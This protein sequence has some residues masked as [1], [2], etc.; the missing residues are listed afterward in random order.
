[1][2]KKA[3]Y[4]SAILVLVIAIFFF[5]IQILSNIAF[6]GNS[7]AK[8]QNMV[9]L[10][11]DDGPNP[12]YTPQILDILRQHNIKATFFVLGSKAEKHPGIIKRIAEEGHEIGIHSYSHP[13]LV[14]RSRKTMAKEIAYTKS[15]IEIHTNKSIALF[16]PPYGIIDLGAL[17]FSR[18]Q[19]L[20]IVDWS[21]N[22]KDYKLLDS[23]RITQRVTKKAKPGDIVLFHDGGGTTR[24]PTVDALPA[25]IARLREKGHYPVLVSEILNE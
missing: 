20:G 5:I 10:T 13:L 24:Q 11:F 15:L 3:I 18:R 22:S 8:H 9:A 12:L 21:L 16:R 6:S 2:T 19:E 14:F 1:M 7:N 17:S 4:L 25:I 23:A